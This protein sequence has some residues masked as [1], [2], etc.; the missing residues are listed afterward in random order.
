MLPPFEGTLGLTGPSAHLD[1]QVAV[2]LADASL[3]SSLFR[4]P[5]DTQV[6]R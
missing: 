6:Q 3:N 4:E 1:L 5:E 2:S